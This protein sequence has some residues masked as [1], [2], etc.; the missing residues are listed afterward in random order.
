MS[1]IKYKNVVHNCYYLNCHN[2]FLNVTGKRALETNSV[3]FNNYS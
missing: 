2:N 1:H 3:W